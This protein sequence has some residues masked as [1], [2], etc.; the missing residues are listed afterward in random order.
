MRWSDGPT[1]KN[2][3]GDDSKSYRGDLSVKL[4]SVPDL[5]GMEI[6]GQDFSLLRWC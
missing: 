3:F 5:R 2:P 4:G 6:V 1:L